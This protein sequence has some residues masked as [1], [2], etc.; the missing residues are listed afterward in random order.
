V[1][2]EKI[3]LG[4]RRVFINAKQRI[5][6]HVHLCRVEEGAPY[7]RFVGSVSKQSFLLD[8]NTANKA[9]CTEEPFVEEGGNIYPFK[10][11]S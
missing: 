2:G 3:Y 1:T 11:E 5:T 10:K 9:L 4:K 7:F 6:M 8:Y